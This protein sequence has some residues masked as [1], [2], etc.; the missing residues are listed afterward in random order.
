MNIGWS[1]RIKIGWQKVER[2]VGHFKL[3]G[4]GRSMAQWSALLRL[5]GK[6]PFSQSIHSHVG[7]PVPLLKCRFWVSR[8]DSLISSRWCWSC[9]LIDPTE[10]L[11]ANTAKCWRAAHPSQDSELK[12][13]DCPSMKR[14]LMT[15][16]RSCAMGKEGNGI[17]ITE[18]SC[19][20]ICNAS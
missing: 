10:Q 12:H 13:T 9:W 15:C 6:L 11:G 2:L 18:K 4:Q 8:S 14:V 17:I 5:G 19:W 3:G 1:C 20:F 16:I 7:C